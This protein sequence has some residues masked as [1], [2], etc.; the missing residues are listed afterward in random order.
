[1]FFVIF[2]SSLFF[3]NCGSGETNPARV[4]ALP[5]SSVEPALVSHD[6]DSGKTYLSEGDEDGDDDTGVPSNS[7]SA[8]IPVDSTSSKT[9]VLTLTGLGAAG[10]AAVW[11][12]WKFFIQNS[13]NPKTPPREASFSPTSPV[14]TPQPKSN[15]IAEETSH[16]PTSLEER[17]QWLRKY[18]TPERLSLLDNLQGL[19]ELHELLLAQCYEI[20]PSLA[21]LRDEELNRASDSIEALKVIFELIS[22]K[23]EEGRETNQDS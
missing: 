18:L 16:Y 13:P 6:F 22:R 19:N 7:N 2:I 10:L 17:E 15:P 14:Q 23:K 5:A 12:V 8:Q 4:L 11:C 21:S 3:I 9:R 20:M 1:M